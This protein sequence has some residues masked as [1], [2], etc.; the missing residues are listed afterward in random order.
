MRV[1]ALWESALRSA[2]RGH[3]DAMVVIHPS[4]W[5]A[6]RVRV[7][8]AAGAAVAGQTRTRT[9]SSLLREA[10]GAAP[11]ATVVIEI[12][13]RLVA[14]TANEVTAVPRNAE[15][16][17]VAHDVAD[18]VA[19][20]CP[21]AVMIDVPSTVTGSS[22]LARLIAD[23]GA[24]DRTEGPRRTRNRRPPAGPSRAARAPGA[25]GSRTRRC[26]TTARSDAERTRGGRDRGRRGGTDRGE[27]G[28]TRWR[29]AEAGPRRADNLFGGR[30]GGGV[31]PGGVVDP[32][33]DLRAGLGTGTGHVAD[34][35]PKWLCTSPSPRSR[36]RRCAPPPT[37]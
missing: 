31:G 37:G 27:H 34:T 7:V 20:M 8:S 13:E 9:R 15:P 28:P 3:C 4:W 30:P 5:S 22:A 24:G 14:I 32:T 18:V 12:A 11:D 33:G 19:G 2:A 10:S 35:T 36:A 25:G 21:A 23:R 17:S 16:Q 29:R 1:A 6:S 26:R